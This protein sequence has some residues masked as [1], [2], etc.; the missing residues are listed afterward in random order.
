VA[1]ASEKQVAQV[2]GGGLV[3]AMLALWPDKEEKG[4]QR[5]WSAEQTV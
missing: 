4:G 3:V 2:A 5:L 1:P